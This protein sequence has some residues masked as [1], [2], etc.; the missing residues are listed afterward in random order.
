MTGFFV[1]FDLDSHLL[2]K[3]YPMAILYIAFFPPINA[4][5]HAIFPNSNLYS[6]YNYNYYVRVFRPSN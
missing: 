1:I 4:I 3:L 6:W 2:K 5:S